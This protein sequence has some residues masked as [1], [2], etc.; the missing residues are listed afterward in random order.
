VT[1]A[2]HSEFLKL[3]TTRLVAA[4]TGL[5]VALTALIGVLEAVSAGTGKGMAIPSL[6]TAGGLR[7]NLASTGFGILV[8]AL[9]GTVIATSEFRFKTATDTYLDQPSRGRVLGAKAVAAAAAGAVLGLAAAAT[10]TGI[11]LGFA[12]SRGYSLALS[13]PAITRYAGGTVIASAL[14][15]AAGAGVG[16]LIRHQVGAVITVVA[17]GLVVEL[18][19]SATVPGLG[20]FLPYTAAAMMAGDT[21]GG[22]M[23]QIPRGVAA[24]PYPAAVLVLAGI[25]AA[26]AVAAA[27]TAV[28][29]DIT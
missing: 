16:S 4:M 9:L 2:L 8:A 15:A 25:A 23:P 17:W 27:L 20:R 6:D 22:G 14:L 11:A 12:A 28:R 5:A 21:N 3:R 24:L 13:G 29:H 19:V 10:A 26:V 18:V 1:A 7:D